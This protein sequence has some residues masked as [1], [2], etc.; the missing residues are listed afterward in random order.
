M[1][2]L[3]Y[4]EGVGESYAQKLREADVTTTKTLLELGTT[5]KGRKNIAAKSGLSDSL[6]SKWVNHVDLYRVKGIGSEYAELLEISGVDTVVEL[7][8]R[9]PVNLHAKMLSINLDKKLVRKPPSKSQVKNWVEQ[10]KQLPRVIT[11]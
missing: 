7:A 10:A 3:T 8:Q 5:P 6:I 11:Y 1:A 4:I 9:N 2:K